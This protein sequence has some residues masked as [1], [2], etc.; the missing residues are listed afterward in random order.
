[1]P[2]ISAS[3]GVLTY[4]QEKNI[5]TVC[6]KFINNLFPDLCKNTDWFTLSKS[7]TA[8]PEKGYIKID[9]PDSKT[10]IA[11]HYPVPSEK[12]EE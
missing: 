9:K 2:H 5:K 7:L 10:S 6:G 1:M 8:D 3:F 11:F 4:S 12:E